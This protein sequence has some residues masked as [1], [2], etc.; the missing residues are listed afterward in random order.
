MTQTQTPTVEGRLDA[1]VRQ[2]LRGQIS[3]AEARVAWRRGEQVCLLDSAL[4][5]LAEATYTILQLRVLSAVS[6]APGSSLSDLAR[7]LGSRHTPG[8][9]VPALAVLQH[10]GLVVEERAAERRGTQK[11]AYAVT[12]EGN[13]LLWRVAEDVFVATR[14]PR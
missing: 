10:Q 11:T 4:R 5:A 1:I 2:D 7:A 8:G 9:I 6:A 14:P 12:V 13:A 3:H